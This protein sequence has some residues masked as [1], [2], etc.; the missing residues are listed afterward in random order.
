MTSDVLVVGAGPV[1]LVMAAELARYGL[2]VRLVDKAAQR[3][4][5]SKALVVWSRTLEL[6][7]RM[8]SSAALVQ[9]GYKVEGINIVAGDK[10]IGHVTLKGLPTPYPY[11][12]MIPQSE[13]ER[14]LDE[15][16]NTLGVKVEREVELIEFTDERGRV[17]STLRHSAG[18]EEKLET[19]WLIGCDGA[20]STVR[21]HLGLKFEGTTLETDWILADLHL[22]GMPSPGEI[23]IFWHA[24]GVLATFPISEHRFRVIA[25][26]GEAHGNQLRPDPTLE[27]IQAVLN[28]RGPGGIQVSAPIWL[29][30]FRINERKVSSY[31][32]GRVFVA[33]DAAHIHSPAG[34]QGMNTG[35]Q[36]ACNLAWKLALVQMGICSPEPLL[37]SY[38]AE[39]SEIG[40]QVLK[41]ASRITSI[42][43]L[44]GEIK[45]SIRDH[46]AS[47]VF[48]LSPVQRAISNVV[49]E[50]SIGYPDSP[51]NTRG[52]HL[53]GGPV[54]GERAPILE[55]QRPFGAGNSPYFALCAEPEQDCSE[56]IADYP[57]LVDPNIRKP[58]AAGGVWLVRPDGYVVLAT[59]KGNLAPVSAFLERIAAP[60]TAGMRVQH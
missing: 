32:A 34:G 3:T 9:A 10:P 38:S 4:D 30:A 43:I 40:E 56:L 6:M 13:T 55:G 59:R 1:G 29:A 18:Q 28:Q 37:D 15:H 7:D 48:G 57:G 46:L 42:A 54:A 52:S 50:L 49:T 17:R 20:H 36:D 31:R 47:L 24:E 35:M 11:A 39:R 41:A 25:D 45:Q 23:S 21:H 12:L 51:L 16:L 22:D 2:S 26:V 5:K 27:E 44:R 14:V 19:S 33:G 60:S 8:G 58:F 53:S